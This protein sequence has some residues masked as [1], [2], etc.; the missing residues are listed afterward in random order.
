MV[1]LK[2]KVLITTSGVGQRLGELTKHTNQSLVTLVKKPILS[3]IMEAYPSEVEVVVTLGYFGGLVKEFL[4][5]AYPK[6][7]ITYVDV[8]NYNGPGS[9][10]GY[11]MLQ[12]KK[13][14]QCPF[15]IHAGDTVVMQEI[16]QPLE[17]WVGGAKGVSTVNYRSFTELDEKVYNFNDKGA[18]DFDFLHIGLV[19]IKDY[20]KFWQALE[21]IYR[22]NPQDHSLG[23]VP[24][25][26]SLIRSGVSFAPKEFRSWLDIGNIDALISA[27]KRLGDPLV[28][29][30]K[31]DEATYIFDHSVIKFIS[32]PKVVANRVKRAKLLGRLVPALE[33]SS[34][35]Y[36]RYRFVQGRL[37]ARS[38]TP[39]DFKLFLDWAEKNLWKKAREAN[40]GEFEKI[41][42]KF[43]EEKTLKRVKQFYELTGIKDEETVINGEVVP[44]LEDILAQIDFNWLARGLQSSFHGDF[45]LD[46]ILRTA[47]GYKLLDWRQD[48]G[49]LLKAGDRYYD[50][51]KLNHNLTV[52]HDV[53]FRNQFTI[54]VRGNTVTCDILRPQILVDCQKILWD[55]AEQKGYNLKKIKVLTALIWL[56]SAPL[57]H[58]PY[59]LF[60]YYFGKLNL[61]KILN[62]K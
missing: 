35:H 51:A 59:N 22:Q 23:D 14:L 17:N 54:R 6:R 60:L 38:V 31:T 37:Y 28:N 27:R 29:L 46:N 55:F 25:L 42:R 45:I 49:G 18:T 11:S 41:C 5:L 40:K 13:H 15:I 34:K 8:K 4:Q 43:Y 21:G 39:V 10:M 16:P 48:F 33:S 9:S 56:N 58:H 19:G 1:K 30:D 3:H 47:D 12:A 52:N 2:Y 7:K 44:K 50:L 62:E 57:H 32:N 61:W 20:E 53:V 26:Q 24:V 36:Y